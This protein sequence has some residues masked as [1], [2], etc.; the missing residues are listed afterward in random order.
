M[1]NKVLKVIVLLVFIMSMALPSASFASTD[2]MEPQLNDQQVNLKSEE[3]NK[4]ESVESQKEKKEI[5]TEPSIIDT[6]GLDELSTIEKGVETESETISDEKSDVMA[7]NSTEKAHSAA[8]IPNEEINDEITPKKNQV[9]DTRHTRFIV[10]Q[11]SSVKKVTGIEQ[12]TSRLG[13]LRS[14]GVRIYKSYASQSDYM[15]AG[16][17]YTNEVYYIK[18]Q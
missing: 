3:I 16:S 14:S 12:K 10:A 13:H 1:E 18:K 6:K 2:T 5:N 15:N 4:E 7:P 11:S 9:V 17:T 8:D